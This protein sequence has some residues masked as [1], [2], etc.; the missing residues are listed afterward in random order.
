MHAMPCYVFPYG[1]K[2]SINYKC[3]ILGGLKDILK[4][5]LNCNPSPANPLTKW[6]NWM[7]GKNVWRGTALTI[8]QPT[9]MYHCWEN[10]G[11]MICVCCLEVRP[12]EAENNA[13]TVLAFFFTIC[14][15]LVMWPE[16]D[17]P[18]GRGNNIRH[19]LHGEHS[20]R[21][22]WMLSTWCH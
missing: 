11:L 9:H 21:G 15:S 10:V 17:I 13:I 6:L 19:C 22:R 5:L 3:S 7:R 14:L 12:R 1:V 2:H 18:S 8:H 16:G 20:V 4:I